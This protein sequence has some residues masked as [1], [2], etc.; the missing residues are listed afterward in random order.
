MQTAYHIFKNHPDFDKIKFIIV[1]KMKEG[2]KACSDIPTNINLTI[3][4][5]EDKLPNLNWDLINDYGNK[6]NYFFEDLQPSII[7]ELK[8]RIEPKEGDPLGNNLFDLLREKVKA[9][10]PKRTECRFFSFCRY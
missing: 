9:N 7:E 8:D 10:H 4:E 6:L 3:K 5:F 2:L 1:P